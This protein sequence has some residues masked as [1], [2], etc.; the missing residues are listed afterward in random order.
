[1]RM[2][3]VEQAA[4]AAARA[5]A[6]QVAALKERLEAQAAALVAADRSGRRVRPK[7]AR[8]TDA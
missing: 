5:S 6:S 2:A 1:M 7:S 3:M 8:T 4:D